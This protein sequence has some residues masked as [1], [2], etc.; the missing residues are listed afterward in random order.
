MAMIV[1]GWFLALAWRRDHTERA[2]VVVRPAP[3]DAGQLD[4]DRVRVPRVEAIRKGLLGQPDMQIE[5]NG[6]Y[7][8][9]LGGSRTGRHRLGEVPRPWV[10]SVSMWWYRGLMLAWALWLAWSLIRWVPWAWQSFGAGGLW[11]PVTPTPR[12]SEPGR[13]RRRM[14]GPHSGRA[15]NRSAQFGGRWWS[16]QSADG[17][18]AHVVGVGGDL[19]RTRGD[20]LGDVEPSA[21][22]RMASPS[23]TLPSSRGVAPITE[24]RCRRRRRG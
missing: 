5:G 17:A 6:S 15:M 8:S 7:G 16:T 3:A 18:G 12:P 22:V 1:I 23:D 9:S 11:R 21:P 19:R 4:A 14:N 2:G 10:L 24:R 20:S 13:R